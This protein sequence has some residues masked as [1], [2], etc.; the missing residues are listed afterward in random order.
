MFRRDTLFSSRPTRISNYCPTLLQ[1]SSPAGAADAAAATL[2]LDVAWINATLL[3]VPTN[4][5]RRLRISTFSIIIPTRDVSDI[6]P[7]VTP[8]LRKRVFSCDVL[9]IRLT[10]IVSESEISPANLIVQHCGE[11]RMKRTRSRFSLA[12]Y[13]SWYAEDFM[14]KKS[15][16]L[17]KIAFSVV[18][19]S[20]NQSI[21]YFFRI[22]NEQ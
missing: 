16:F 7:Q 20:I 5:S 17:S 19:Q 13:N 8:L 10:D 14:A 4:H 9:L 2:V 6:G 3:S 21:I 15:S 12:Y 18:N 11:R 1:L 22:T